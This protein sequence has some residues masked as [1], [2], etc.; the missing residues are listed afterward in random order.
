MTELMELIWNF[1]RMNASMK[2][3]NIDISKFPLGRLSKDQIKKGFLILT[4]I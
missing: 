4:N 3:M 1:D 2:E